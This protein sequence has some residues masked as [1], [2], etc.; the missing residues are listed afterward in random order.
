MAVSPPLDKITKLPAFAVDIAQVQLN[1]LIDRILEEMREVIRDVAVLPIDID[2]EDPRIKKT[3]KTLT[4]IQGNLEKVQENIPKIQK[5]AGQVKQAIQIAVGIK[6]AIAIAQLSNPI[7]VSLYIAATIE[8][9]QDETIANAIDAITPLEAL[10]EQALQKLTTL[11]PPLQE[12]I[13]KLIPVCNGEDLNLDFPVARRD[14][15]GVG[16]DGDGDGDAGGDGSGNQFPPGF[17]YNSL[18]PS[19]FYR[20]VNVSEI[21]LD[22]RSDAIQQLLE[23]QQNLLTSLLES[24]SQ[25]YKQD[26]PPPN[27]LGKAGDFYI[28]TQNNIPYGPKPSDTAWGGPLN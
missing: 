6:N 26:G 7:T 12:A 8:Q 17:D 5:L 4:D 24:P 1:L 22:Q 21:D 25:V 16:G 14:D 18:L 10:P 2:C 20:D 23:Q 3:K 15:D 11:I 13:A 9:L 28:D 27:N 19:K